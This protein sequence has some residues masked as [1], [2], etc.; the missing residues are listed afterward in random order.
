LKILIVNGPNLNLIGKREEAFYGL[1]DF[2]EIFSELQQKFPDLDLEYYQS[3]HEG[4]I[5]DRL[6]TA[7]EEKFGGIV[8]NAA[9]Y[10]HTSIAIR[11]ALE[12]L[13]IPR[14]EVHFSNIYRREPFRNISVISA[15]CQGTITGFGKHSYFLA[16]EWFRVNQL[17][18]IG[19]K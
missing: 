2:G 5:V 14:I 17:K 8:I 13:D 12:M 10:S 7:M 11:D 9:G 19:F 1:E 4:G 18:R 16:L 6:Q 3:N 15:V